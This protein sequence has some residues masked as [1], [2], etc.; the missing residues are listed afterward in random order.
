MKTYGGVDVGVF[1]WE[2]GWTPE[3]SIKIKEQTLPKMIIL[4][5][6]T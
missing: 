5:E 1:G 6:Y 2:A 4:K 3:Q